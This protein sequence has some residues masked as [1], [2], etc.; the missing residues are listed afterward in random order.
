MTTLQTFVIIPPKPPIAPVLETG[1][2]VEFGG[3]AAPEGFLLC[4]G[5]S[6][7][8]ATHPELH[9]VIG[10]LYGGDGGTNFNVPELRGE[11]VRGLSD[12][13][14]VGSFQNHAFLAHNHL[15]RVD[16]QNATQFTRR[17]ANTSGSTLNSSSY[18]GAETRPRNVAMP[19]IIKT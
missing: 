3:L 7:L 13:R 2:I 11:F 8:V 4:D 19:Y 12:G 10:D 15:N 16:R 14:A 5:A 1:V 17:L 18:G 6:Y 9:A